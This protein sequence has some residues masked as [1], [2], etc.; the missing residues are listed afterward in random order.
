MTI[1]DRLDALKAAIVAFVVLVVYSTGFYSGAYY[2]RMVGQAH[3]AMDTGWYMSL[4]SVFLMLA[5][6]LIRTYLARRGISS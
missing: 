5:A 1:L 2:T 4:V 3:I 6:I